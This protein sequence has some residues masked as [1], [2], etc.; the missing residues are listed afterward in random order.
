MV[1]E[2]L[3]RTRRNTPVL[4]LKLMSG[5]LELSTNMV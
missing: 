3:Q 4:M 5:W 2:S 1:L